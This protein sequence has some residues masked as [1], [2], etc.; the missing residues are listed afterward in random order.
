MRITMMLVLA[1][2]SLPGIVLSS[3][4]AGG[5]DQHELAVT[6]R[7]V[8]TPLLK[9]RLLPAEHELHEGNAAPILLRLPWDQTAFF[10]R[11]VPKF[12]SY[13]QIPLADEG[14]IREAGAGLPS[15]FYAE[16]RRAAYRRTASWEYPS[17]EKPLAEILLPDVQGGRDIVARGLSVWIR[18]HIVTNQSEQALEG[19]LVG[20]ADARHYA[21]TPF[22]IIQ[23][24][25]VALTSRMLD[26]LEEL[27]QRPEA[28]NLYWSLTALPT[29]FIN[30]R[31]ALEFE[32]E[33]LR[34]SV[35]GL[36]D[37]QRARS[38]DEWQTLADGMVR[39][40]ADKSPNRDS[41]IQNAAAKR[42]DT[43][44]TA[45]RE[46][47][48]LQPDLDQRVSDMSDGELMVRWVLSRR[49]ELSD[50]I[51]TTFALEPVLAVERLRGIE[52]EIR[53]YTREHALLCLFMME[54]PLDIYL[55]SFQ[56]D[57]R[58][59]ALRVV[60]GVRH[61]AATHDGQLPERLEQ[62]TET[63]APRDP[64]SGKPFEYG[65]NVKTGRFRVVSPAI[66]VDD[67]PHNAIEL[68][69]RLQSE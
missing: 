47:P 3:S 38:A 61:Y 24:F 10:A 18:Y 65:A 11:E 43:L 52:D 40:I 49:D 34:R 39:Y 55:A 31:P 36:D 8:E 23:T 62:L 7:A 22:V 1:C 27:I 21:R 16:L 2:C 64:L 13:L 17:D 51:T 44:A 37:L 66:A 33:F 14:R 28:P 41:A 59:A 68:E 46:L 48:E 63:P 25:A 4:A 56:F 50:R 15:G 67:K 20:L 19:I 69:V 12:E 9:R 54:Q 35:A 26:R 42:K 5:A 53:T 57:R 32:H 45:R 6:A 58:V 30:F 29:P 60:E